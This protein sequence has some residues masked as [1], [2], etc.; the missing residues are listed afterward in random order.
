MKNK[1]SSLYPHFLSQLIPPTI[2]TNIALLLHT[3]QGAKHFSNRSKIEIIKSDLLTRG[4]PKHISYVQTRK[5]NRLKMKIMKKRKSRQ[6]KKQ[7]SKVG[8]AKIPTSSGQKS[9]SQKF[10]HQVVQSR[11]RKNSK[12]KFSK[13]GVAKISTPCMQKACNFS[14]GSWRSAVGII[15]Q[16]LNQTSSNLG[17]EI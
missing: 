15:F 16:K 7:W 10:K 17:Q 3:G 9:F 6:R 12:L 11:C 13:V 8:V 14:S 5:F 1:H 4:R 2:A